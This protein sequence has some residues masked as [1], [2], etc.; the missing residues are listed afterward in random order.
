MRR[1]AANA[2]AGRRLHR[3]PWRRRSA[4]PDRGRSAV[5]GRGF[6][7]RRGGSVA[8][9][10]VLMLIGS[11]LNSATQAVA[12]AAPAAGAVGPAAVHSSVVTLVTGDRVVVTTDSGGRQRAAMLP[13]PGTAGSAGSGGFVT[14]SAG[15]DLYVVPD[16]ALPYVGTT[17][18]QSLFNVSRL[19]ENSSG[20]R[21]VRVQESAGSAVPHRTF[22]AWPWSRPAPASRMA[23]SRRPAASRSAVRSRGS[24]PLTARPGLADCPG[25]PRPTCSAVSPGLVPRGPR[26]RWSRPT[27]P[28]RP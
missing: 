5:S 9:L 4:V 15:P 25:R 27:S 2:L 18:D 23:S 28:C 10:A 17:L 6:R 26:R 7:L 24:G 19:A 20:G 16:T 11:L 21:S 14:M 22:P 1:T 12:H 8:V 13:A 3:E